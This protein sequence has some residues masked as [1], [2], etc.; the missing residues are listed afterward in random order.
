MGSLGSSLR[1]FQSRGEELI[2]RWGTICRDG[3]KISGI[4]LDTIGFFSRSI[5][6]LELLSRVFEIFDP[7]HTP[8]APKDISQC[9]FGFVKTDQYDTGASDDVKAIWTR[10][11]ELL[12]S[13]GA[14]VDEV[15]LGPEFDGVGGHHGK[16]GKLSVAQGGINFLREYRVAKEQLDES[17]HGWVENKQGLS[18]KEV[19]AIEDELAGLRPKMDKI[20]GG[21]DALITPSAQG[22]AP[23]GTEHTGSPQF[24]AM[25]TAL[26]MPVINI[27]GF[28]GSTGMPIGLTM[29]A[30]R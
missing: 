13:A 2:Y 28:A 22:E 16:A 26:H 9:R 4:S 20:A 29:V 12:R 5:T 14:Q 18:K 19:F 17:L 15:D 21:Y 27:P 24:C 6:D 3:V 23:E 11:Q 7:I 30:P 1:T 10:A 25:W 8:S